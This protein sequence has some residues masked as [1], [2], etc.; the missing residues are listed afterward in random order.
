MSRR[1]KTRTGC[2]WKIVSLGFSPFS[3]LFPHSFSFL[4]FSLTSSKIPFPSIIS[5]RLKYWNKKPHALP[6]SNWKSCP[7]HSF[8]DL[9]VRPA[10]WNYCYILTNKI[11][12]EHSY[13]FLLLQ[14]SSCVYAVKQEWYTLLEDTLGVAYPF[15][16]PQSN[17]L[18]KIPQKKV[19]K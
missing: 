3:S 10:N 6:H 19:V 4:T 14:F 7:M 2:A 9:R 13:D 12:N 16:F 11:W 8:K 17:H 5:K 18:E 15:S 1:R